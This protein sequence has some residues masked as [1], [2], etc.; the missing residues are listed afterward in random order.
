VSSVPLRAA[1]ASPE[2]RH[3]LTPALADPNARTLAGHLARFGGLPLV[4]GELTAE[5]AKA[6]LRGRGG[7]AFRTELKLHAVRAASGRAIVVANGAE[8][9]PASKKDKLLL[10]SAPHLVL[11]GVVAAAD[12]VG[13]GAGIVALSEVAQTEASALRRAIAERRRSERIELTVE[14]VPD[15]FV[16]G[17]ET[18]LVRALGGGP[19]KPSVKPPYP[20]E[21]GFRGRPTLV[22]NV[23]TLAHLALIARYGA[24]WFRSVGPDDSPGTALVTLSGAV[25]RPGIYEAELGA[26]LG[27]L[28]LRAGGVS[29]PVSAFLVGGYF[30]QWVSADDAAGTRLTPESLGSGA[31]VALPA[32]TCAVAECVRV[33]GYL[34]GQSAGQCGPCAHGLPAIAEALRQLALGREGRPRIL[35]WTGHVDGRGACRHPNGAARFVESSLEVFGTEFDQHARAGRCKHSDRGV[36]PLPGRSGH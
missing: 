20:F 16:S 12:A 9:E 34:A 36:L 1:P 6:G 13:A 31:I 25:V 18:A 15:G 11:D 27:D 10:R 21:R 17:E 24:A 28:V 2:G 5:V 35:R 32:S 22:Q 4:G 19:P 33:A 26:T 29:E 30:G 14:T 8:G 3:R 23:E 7:A